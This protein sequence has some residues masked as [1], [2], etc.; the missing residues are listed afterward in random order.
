[1]LVT[2]SIFTGFLWNERTAGCVDASGE[3]AADDTPS[4]D[5]VTNW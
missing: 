3:T 5:M 2:S 4:S 1:M